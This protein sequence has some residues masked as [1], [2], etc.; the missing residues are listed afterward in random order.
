MLLCK[1]CEKSCKNDNSLRNHQRMCGDNPDKQI[2]P[3]KKYKKDNPDPWNKG[4]K[5]HYDVWTK[6][7]PGTF[8]GKK[9]N[10]DAKRK[11]AEKINERYANGW[12]CVAGRCKKYFH[13]SSIAGDMWVDGTWEVAFCKFADST[14]LSWKRNKKRF[15][16]IKPNGKKSTYQ[17]DFYIE[18][19]NSYIEIKGY[20]TDLDRA[21]WDQFPKE[22]NLI[23]LRRKEIGEL[24]EWFKSVSC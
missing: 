16:Y 7:K 23:V 22:L 13:S 2:S 18:E 14:G 12:E 5:L 10:D 9:H 17:P 3:F 15:P 1:F 6:G 4:K 20:E 8:L 21:K 24:D 11:M 19:L